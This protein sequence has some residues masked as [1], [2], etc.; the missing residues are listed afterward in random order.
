MGIFG[1]YIGLGWYHYAFISFL[2]FIHFV[3][4]SPLYN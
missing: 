2:E 3:K 4:E 1:E